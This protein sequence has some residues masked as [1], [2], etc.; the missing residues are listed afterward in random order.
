MIDMSSETLITLPQAAAI[1]PG[2]PS[3][4]TL[5]RW[6]LRGVAGR[7]LESVQIGGRVYTSREALQ[8]FAQ[9]SGGAPAATPRT[10]RQRERAIRAAER[11]L[12]DTRI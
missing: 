7:R 2:R 3:V 4:A 6:R 8:R 12:A 9:P 11:E 5:W 10:T 1:L